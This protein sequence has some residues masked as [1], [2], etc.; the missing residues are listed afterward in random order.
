ME[1]STTTVQSTGPIQGIS[2]DLDD[3]L[4]DNRPVIE[5]AERDHYRWLRDNYPL[6]TE[7]YDIRALHELRRETARSH[8]QLRHDLG[9]IRIIS[10]ATA[11]AAVGY[12][13]VMAEEAF[14]TFQ[15]FRNQVVLYREVLPVLRQLRGRFILGALTNG[16]AEVKQMG[17]AGLFHFVLSARTVGAAK[18]ELPIFHEAVRRIGGDPGECV[19]VGDDPCTDIGG[20]KA[21]GLRTVWVNRKGVAWTGEVTPD[22]EI[23]TLEELPEVLARL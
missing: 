22:A 18:P 7:R 20:A 4:Y 5:K 3:T 15:G 10:L 14:R 16:T 8:R 6:L 23:S 17:L 12:S 9:A 13:P 2:F 19:H 1:I 21:A 11:A